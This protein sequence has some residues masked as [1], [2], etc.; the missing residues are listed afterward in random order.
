MCSSDLA[1]RVVVVPG[2]LAREGLGLCPD[3]W[4]SL[5]RRVDA[6]I[7]CAVRANHLESYNGGG[8]SNSM[9]AQNVGGMRNVLR[10][11]VGGGRP[12]TLCHASSLLAETRVSESGLLAE[13]FPTA[14]DYTPLLR[15]GYS[16]SKFV[17]EVLLGQAVAAGLRGAKVLRY[18]AIW[19]HSQT[20]FIAA[21]G[22]HDHGSAF[23]VASARIGKFPVFDGVD[24]AAVVPVDVAATLT[25]EI[26]LRSGSADGVYNMTTETAVTQAVL[27]RVMRERGQEVEFLP[28]PE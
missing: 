8:S 10:F 28:V 2:D 3:E 22:G 19:G 12:K 26:L 7:H 5:S 24:S 6:V 15:N 17:S 9:R 20:G 13:D 18:P 14:V 23:L 27:E 1:S 21:D 11:V 4:D 25:L 16:V